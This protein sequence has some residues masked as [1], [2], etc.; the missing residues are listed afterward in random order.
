MERQA[1][2][3][4]DLNWVHIFFLRNKIEILGNKRRRMDDGNKMGLSFPFPKYMDESAAPEAF[5]PKFTYC[6]GSKWSFLC[7]CNGHFVDEST[8]PR[9]GRNT[10]NMGFR[11]V[12]PD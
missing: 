1:Q 2:S 3:S 8:L 10:R 5:R 12:R 9:G 7:Q 4:S 6:V 11:L